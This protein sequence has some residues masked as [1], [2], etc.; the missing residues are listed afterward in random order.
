MGAIIG[1]SVLKNIAAILL[2]SPFG[3]YDM[4]GLRN[5]RNIATN[6]G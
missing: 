4:E 2:L 6:K 3:S 5:T 1:T